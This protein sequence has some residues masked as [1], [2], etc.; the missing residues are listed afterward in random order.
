M[1]QQFLQI[2]L[3][4][5]PS[6]TRRAISLNI[7]HSFGRGYDTQQ[8]IVWWKNKWVAKREIPQQKNRNDYSL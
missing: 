8:N 7:A 6:Q 3:K 4:T 1:V 2:Q 5:Q